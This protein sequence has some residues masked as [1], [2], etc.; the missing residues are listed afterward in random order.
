MRNVLKGEPVV[1]KSAGTQSRSYCYV[2]ECVTG[3]LYIL[4]NGKNKNAYNIAN[5]ASEITVKELAEAVALAGGQELVIESAGAEE[6]KGYS[7]FTKAVLNADKLKSLGWRPRYGL[8][9]GIRNS[10]EILK[11][12]TP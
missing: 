6:K 11:C 5:D 7:T 2:A 1:L 3:L 12:K 8:D 10:L 9:E 4:T